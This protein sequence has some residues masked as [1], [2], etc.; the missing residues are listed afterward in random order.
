MSELRHGGWELLQDQFLMNN[1]T[2]PV[3]EYIL[4]QPTHRPLV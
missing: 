2:P 3:W 1:I 4:L